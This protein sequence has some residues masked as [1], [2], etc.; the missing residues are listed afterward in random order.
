[1]PIIHNFWS[2][3]VWYILRTGYISSLFPLYGAAKEMTTI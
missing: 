2:E 3:P 1:L